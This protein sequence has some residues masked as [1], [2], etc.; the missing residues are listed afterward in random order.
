VAQILPEGE[1]AVSLPREAFVPVIQ[2]EVGSDVA[3]NVYR[4]KI[5]VPLAQ[6]I[7]ETAEAVRRVTIATGE[8]I[9]LLMRLLTEH[10]GGLTGTVFDPPILRGVG[11]RD[12][13]QP[14]GSLEENE[15]AA[16]E[17]YARRTRASP[18]PGPTLEENEHAAFEVYAAPLQE[19]DDY[20][21]TLRKELQE[22]LAEGVIL[23]E[24]QEVVLV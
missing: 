12:P 16:F 6:T 18:S 4:Y 20:F 17:V 21:R 23:I 3:V 13:K 24:R 15:H 14:A 22:A 5:L 10:F 11:A 7:R 2:A 19:S 1:G 9:R 8:D